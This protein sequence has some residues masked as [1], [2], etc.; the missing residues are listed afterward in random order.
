MSRL[1]AFASLL[2]LLLP[3]PQAA[4]IHCE[5][6]AN[7]CDVNRQ[8]EIEE[9]GL[10]R[11]LRH[12]TGD[13]QI[14]PFAISGDG[15]TLAGR[16]LMGGNYVAFR[17]TGFC[18]AEEDYEF[19]DHCDAF[20]DA[21]DVGYVASALSHDGSVAA[22]TADLIGTRR[23]VRWGRNGRCRDLGN[24]PNAEVDE[25]GAGALGVSPG[26]DSVVGWSF[27]RHPRV[28]EGDAYVMPFQWGA[29]FDDKLPHFLLVGDETELDGT[30]NALE[31]ESMQGGVAYATNG[32]TI[33]GLQATALGSQAVR[34][35]RASRSSPWLG[36]FTHL[37][38]P[39]GTPSVAID[40][41]ANGVVVGSGI[42]PDSSRSRA[43]RWTLKPG[44]EDG[45][46]EDLGV[47]PGRESATA[48][49]VSADG[50]VVVGQAFGGPPRPTAVVWDPDGGARDLGQYLRDDV[51]GCL[52]Q[53]DH[54]ALGPT[55]Y[56]DALDVSADGSLVLGRV[57]HTPRLGRPF[58]R[59]FLA[60]LPLGREIVRLDFGPQTV[61]LAGGLGEPGGVQASLNAQFG[62]RAGALLSVRV[63]DRD[64]A[65]AAIASNALA[66]TPFDLADG[67]PRRLG[68]GAGR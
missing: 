50:R 56:Q 45:F 7:C 63:L 61:D 35:D 52:P 13:Y 31:T 64:E 53:V 67:D 44:S 16:V 27:G 62:G 46:A 48:R 34:W 25:D 54:F 26:G 18:D 9:A 8:Q 41:S 12:P 28:V 38:A 47:P 5:G 66:D 51:L 37:P 23:A 58:R 55:D 29:G 33:V 19:L 15:S 49:A 65:D 39:W 11:F 40:V 2:A 68:P 24:L 32:D 10:F 4:A 59:H 43:F 6:G 60:Q 36:A 20:G 21:A 3:T 14:E 42:D 57:V 30:P 22:G 1:L 17:C